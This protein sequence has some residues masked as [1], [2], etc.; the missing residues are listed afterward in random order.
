[1]VLLGAGFP[2]AT[3]QT[4]PLW[5]WNQIHQW[6]ARFQETLF[7]FEFLAAPAGRPCIRPGLSPHVSLE[8]QT[9]LS[10]GYN[11]ALRGVREDELSVGSSVIDQQCHLRIISGWSNVQ[12]TKT[13]P[14][15]SLKKAMYTCAC[16]QRDTHTPS[17]RRQISVQTYRVRYILGKSN[18]RSLAF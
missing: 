9:P 18:C 14:R 5:P 13:K 12:T 8:L 16:T 3:C 4:Q 15:V 11:P 17:I 10:R 1:M 2:E 6:P 7:P